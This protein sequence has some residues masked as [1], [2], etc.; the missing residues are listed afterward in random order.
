MFLTT[1]AEQGGAEHS[2]REFGID[3][4]FRF[5]ELFFVDRRMGRNR[6]IFDGPFAAILGRTPI[7]HSFGRVPPALCGCPFFPPVQFLCADDHSRK[8]REKGCGTYL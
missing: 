8:I 6:F 5:K 7:G 1:A 2:D 3:G 4:R